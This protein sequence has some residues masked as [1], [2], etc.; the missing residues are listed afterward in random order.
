MVTPKQ[1]GDVVGGA[2]AVGLV[3]LSLMSP[4]GATSV[5]SG[6]TPVPA[7]V[8]MLVVGPSKSI[9]LSRTRV[10]SGFRGKYSWVGRCTSCYRFHAPVQQQQLA[11]SLDVDATM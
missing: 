8:A 7:A 10:R 2:P 1:S 9:S 6:M 4:S 11:R 5:T 3:S